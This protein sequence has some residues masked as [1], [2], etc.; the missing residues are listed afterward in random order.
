MRGIK[1]SYGGDRYMYKL[2]EDVDM[3]LEYGNFIV[4][5]LKKY[6]VEN[7]ILKDFYL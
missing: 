7:I 5:S 3:N 2:I 6:L 4:V 1:S